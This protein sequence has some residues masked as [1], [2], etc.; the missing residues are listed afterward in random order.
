MIH[1]VIH[2]EKPLIHIRYT[3]VLGWVKL[4]S[5]KYIIYIKLIKLIKLINKKCINIIKYIDTLHIKRKET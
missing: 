2:Y 5:V 3:K 4:V 1:I